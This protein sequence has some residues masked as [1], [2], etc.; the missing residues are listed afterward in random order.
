MAALFY[1][2][3]F[4]DIKE[5]VEEMIYDGVLFTNAQRSIVVEGLR[6][7]LIGIHRKYGHLA[8][9]IYDTIS[10]TFSINDAKRIASDI[11]FDED[12]LN[13]KQYIMTKM[14]RFDYNFI[15]EDKDFNIRMAW[16]LLLAP[17]QQ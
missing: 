2:E 12:D 13:L 16:E 8:L 4:E 6:D 15:N 1:A 10:A 7:E 14:N 5:V 9:L 3:N 11:K 17:Q